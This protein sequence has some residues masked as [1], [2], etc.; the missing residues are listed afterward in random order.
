MLNGT[1][2]VSHSATQ[3]LNIPDDHIKR[4]LV[5]G[6]AGGSACRGCINP[7]PEKRRPNPPKKPMD[8]LLRKPLS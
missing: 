7:S 3:P 8:V 6:R 2:I 4:G 1:T 5:L